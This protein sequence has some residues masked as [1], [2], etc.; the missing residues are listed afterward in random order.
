MTGGTRRARL[1]SAV[2]PYRRGRRGRPRS[3]RRPRHRVIRT[4]S[5]GTLN[6]HPVP[7]CRPPAF[8]FFRIRREEFY[9]TIKLYCT[10]PA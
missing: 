1:K 6:N 4:P 8:Q 3:P 7:G 9:E 5:A 2:Q 10:R